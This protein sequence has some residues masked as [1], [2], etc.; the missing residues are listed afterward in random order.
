MSKSSA[1]ERFISLSREVNKC[2]TAGIRAIWMVS[3]SVAVC[4]GFIIEQ[5]TTRQLIVIGGGLQHPPLS[6]WVYVP[7]VVGFLS[8]IGGLVSFGRRSWLLGAMKSLEE[9]RRADSST[10][11]SWEDDPWIDPPL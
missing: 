3:I 2:Y 5:L 10:R 4:A 9:E 11:Y 7:I 1:D 8:G 6:Q